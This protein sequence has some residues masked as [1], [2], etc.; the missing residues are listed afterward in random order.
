[1]DRTLT[2]DLR[3]DTESFLPDDATVNV[4]WVVGADSFDLGDFTSDP[5]SPS[6][7]SPWRTFVV[8]VTDVYREHQINRLEI[9]KVAGNDNAHLRNV[10]VTDEDLVTELGQYPVGFVYDADVQDGMLAG[11]PILNDG[12]TL[13]DAAHYAEQGDDVDPS[14]FNYPHLNPLAP[15]TPVN[16][17]DGWTCDPAWYYDGAGMPVL[18]KHSSGSD[19]SFNALGYSLCTRSDGLHGAPFHHVFCSLTYYGSR[20]SNGQAAVWG[21]KDASNYW[22]AMPNYNTGSGRIVRVTGGVETTIAPFNVDSWV[23]I[24]VH[25]DFETGLLTIDTYEPF[26]GNVTHFSGV[27][28]W[29]VANGRVG[30]LGRD[31]NGGIFWDSALV[32]AFQLIYAVGTIGHHRQYSM[33]TFSV[34]PQD[35]ATWYFGD[36]LVRPYL[37]H[38]QRD[39]AK[40]ARVHR[41]GNE[42]TSRQYSARQGHR[43]VYL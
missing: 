4:R 18:E 36:D 22:F 13:P 42:P 5:A 43:N 32:G 40:V 35:P 33:E 11:S 20:G 31:Q 19:G 15:G 9:S 2:F 34:V 6:G 1:M 25:H 27:Y 38:R 16:G 21:Y 17:T 28:P 24:T 23:E 10:W 39:D 41:R 8:D 3:A 37:R 30:W 26:L 7:D 29:S 14:P 12:G